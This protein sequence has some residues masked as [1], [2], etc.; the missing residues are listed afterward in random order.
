MLSVVLFEPL[1]YQQHLPSNVII[2][3]LPLRAFT[4]KLVCHTLLIHLNRH[5]LPLDEIPRQSTQRSD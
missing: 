5:D 1:L 3:R 4:V 2:S